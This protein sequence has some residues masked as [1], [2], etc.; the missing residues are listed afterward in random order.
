MMDK[1]ESKEMLSQV[2]IDYFALRVDGVNEN[3]LNKIRELRSKNFKELVDNAIENEEH[4]LEG[5][6]FLNYDGGKHYRLSLKLEEIKEDETNWEVYKNYANTL[7][8]EVNKEEMLFVITKDNIKYKDTIEENDFLC[9]NE[10]RANALC[11][12]LNK[13]DF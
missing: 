10:K 1:N 9:T 6:F 3:H 8:G 4:I 5:V 13:E 2:L 11:D 7:F 12:L